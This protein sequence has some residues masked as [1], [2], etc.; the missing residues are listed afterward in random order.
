MSKLKNFKGFTTRYTS[1]LSLSK[2]QIKQIEEAE[3]Q[4]YKDHHWNNHEIDFDFKTIYEKNIHNFLTKDQLLIL[5]REDEKQKAREK[6]RGKQKISKS[7]KIQE[8]RLKELQLT[9]DQL[10][11]YVKTKLKF[12]KL[13]LKKIKLAKSEKELDLKYCHQKVYEEDIYPIFNAEQ[14]KKYRAIVKAENIKNEAERNKW[15][16]R[17]DK[18]AFEHRYNMKLSEDQAQKLFSIDFNASLKDS[19]G[20]YFS[21]FEMKE[22]QRQW[23][24]KHLTADQFSV[25]N[26]HFEE[27]WNQII[28]RIR[29]SNDTHYKTQLDRTKAYFEFYLKNV[30]PHLVD[31]R[32]RLEDHLNEDQKELI[33]QIHHYYFQQKNK[34]KLN[35]INQHERY[36]KKY[37]P[38]G[39]E[40]FLVRQEMEK[41]NINIYYLYNFEPAKKLMTDEMLLLVK[42][43]S[44]KQREIYK[45]L[46]E[47]QISFYESTG[48]NYGGWLMK[49]PIKEGEEHLNKIGLL[50]IYPDLEKNLELLNKG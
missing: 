19:D 22:K 40:E 15:S 7:L 3:Y 21:D 2:S 33:K 14:L 44:S 10:H 17:L 30:L 34:Q 32:K 36:Y 39:M 42:E 49:V 20:H 38:N 31:S 48:G 43:E 45:R 37:N 29:K 35:Y 16:T 6:E 41:V 5:K 9:N 23:Y 11:T 26:S 47:F 1:L 28:N 46:K 4:L 18:S 8:V 13:T 25:Y 12:T 27:D 50:L 24:K